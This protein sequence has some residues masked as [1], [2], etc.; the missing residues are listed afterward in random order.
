[1]EKTVYL[2]ASLI[3]PDH[4]RSDGSLEPYKSS[5]NIERYV[6][7]PLFKP[8]NSNNEK[9]EFGFAYVA[10][11]FKDEEKAGEIKY[12]KSSDEKKERIVTDSEPKDCERIS[13]LKINKDN[14]FDNFEIEKV[15]TEYKATSIGNDEY[16]LYNDDE[17]MRVALYLFIDNFKEYFNIVPKEK[18]IQSDQEDERY[19]LFKKEF[20]EALNFEEEKNKGFDAEN[21]WKNM[22]EEEKN[23]Y[24]SNNELNIYN[25]SLDQASDKIIY[26]PITIKESIQK[27]YNLLEAKLDNIDEYQ[28]HLLKDLTEDSKVIESSEHFSIYIKNDKN[29][30]ESKKA[31]LTIR[32]NKVNF[33]REQYGDPF[34]LF[35]R[36][37]IDAKYEDLEKLEVKKRKSID[38]S[39][40]IKFIFNNEVQ[41]NKEYDALFC[42][43]PTNK[44]QKDII[45]CPQIIEITKN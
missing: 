6:F 4:F 37:P 16:I 15:F 41:R 12:V 29:K 10:F 21:I 34:D 45:I 33:T 7:F 32:S 24:K 43:D 5:D 36:K 26:N 28:M 1:M 20:K 14:K 39:R 2:Q 25:I 23:K 35:I 38:F 27:E 11:T 31:G 22:K 17:F 9:K 8:E 30:D 18:W 13:I 40:Q 42:K 19:E 44:G 3:T